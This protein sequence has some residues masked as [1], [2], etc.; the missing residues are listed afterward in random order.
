VYFMYM[1]ALYIYV[2]AFVHLC[3]RWV[4]ACMWLH[5]LECTRAC[6]LCAPTMRPLPS[7]AHVWVRPPAYIANAHV[8][9]IYTHIYIDAKYGYVNGYP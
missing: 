6:D 2:Y 7:R 3:E 1:Y 5:R 4:W 9:Y 8:M